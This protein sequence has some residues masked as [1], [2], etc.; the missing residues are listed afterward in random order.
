MWQD[1]RYETFAFTEAHRSFALGT[2]INGALWRRE[3]DTVGIATMR[4]ALSGS[5]RQYLAAGGLGYFIGDGKINYADEQV[6]EMYYSIGLPHNLWTTLDYQYLR[7]PA[8]NADRGPA[9]IAGVRLHW[10]Y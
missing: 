9:T 8:Y 3:Q 2:S 1:G 4:N 6:I 7:N 10:E 5:Y